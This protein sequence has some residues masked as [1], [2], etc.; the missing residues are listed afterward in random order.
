MKIGLLGYGTVGSG[1]AECL[2]NHPMDGVVLTRV[3]DNRDI[4]AIEDILVKDFEVILNDKEIETVVEVMGGEEPAYAYVK[5]A[6][7]AG[8]NVVTANKLMLSLHYDEL[9]NLARSKGVTLAF[10]ATAGGSIPWL[11]NL[12]RAK[13]VDNILSVGGVMNGTTNYILDAMQTDDSVEFDD[14]LKEAQR[15]GFAEADPTADIDGLDVKAKI[16]LSCDVAFS[17]MI[18]TSEIPALGI[19]YIKRKDIA[20][21]RTLGYNCRLMGKAEKKDDGVAAYVEPVLLTSEAEEYNLAGAGNIIAYEAEKMGK[22]AYY[23]LGAGK[24]PTGAAIVNDIYDIASGI[25]VF[26]MAE[27]KKTVKCRPDLASHKYYVR[28][29]SEIDSSIIDEK[30][31]DDVFITKEITVEKMHGIAQN[32]IKSGGQIFA[33]GIPDRK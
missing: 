11:V 4:K 22:Q 7:S 15:L 32:I 28:T 5:K 3:L 10:S 1:A 26:G 29:E 9:V 17:E 13:R 18:D 19:R 2:K 21:F 14:V 30:L 33:A 8:K 12:L 16:A 20:Y 6:L 25:S 24:E 31:A 23:G 27:S